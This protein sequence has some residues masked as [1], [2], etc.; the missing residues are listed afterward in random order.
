MKTTTNMKT[1]T[2]KTTKATVTAM[3]KNEED[4]GDEMI[5]RAR[6]KSGSG[7]ECEHEQKVAG[8]LKGD[9]VLRHTFSIFPSF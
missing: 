4:D 2:T 1:T 8:T 6:D 7:Y 5:Q 9:S 3:M